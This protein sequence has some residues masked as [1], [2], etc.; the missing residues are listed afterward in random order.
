MLLL[1]ALTRGDVKVIAGLACLMSE[2]GQ[3]VSI[4]FD[5]MGVNNNIFIRPLFRF[6]IRHIYLILAYT[7]IPVAYCFT[8]VSAICFAPCALGN[9]RVLVPCLHLAPL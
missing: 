1:P 5:L 3:A 9:I 8:Q 6:I 2:I 4:L 7:H